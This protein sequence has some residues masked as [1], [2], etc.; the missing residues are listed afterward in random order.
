V[1]LPSI[2]VQSPTTMAGGLWQLAKALHFMVWRPSTP[3]PQ[4][5]GHVDACWWPF[6]PCSTFP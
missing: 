2:T 5:P 4:R 6:V 3:A 1:L